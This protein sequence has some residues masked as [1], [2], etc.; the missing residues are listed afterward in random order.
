MTELTTQQQIL[1][2]LK[3]QNALLEEQLRPQR[4]ADARKKN[5]ALIEEE[6]K[7]VNSVTRILWNLY[8]KKRAL[9]ENAWFRR[10]RICKGPRFGEP[11]T[12]LAEEIR[13][14]KEEAEM[15]NQAAAE[16]NTKLWEFKALILKD[17]PEFTEGH[18]IKGFWVQF[19]S[20][21]RKI[22][23]Q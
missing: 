7:K 10:N 19:G 4:E 16:C 15:A 9:D 5:T 12:H 6:K 23:N 11:S 18:D 2:E 20:A 17:F 14:S 22:Y 3:R 13:K 8:R 21:F 1:I